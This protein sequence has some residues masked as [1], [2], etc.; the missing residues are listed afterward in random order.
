VTSPLGDAFKAIADGLVADLARSRADSIARAN[1]AEDTRIAASVAEARQAAAGHQMDAQWKV[2]LPRARFAL[3][4]AIDS[5]GLSE[6]TDSA[7]RHDATPALIDLFNANPRATNA[8]ISDVLAPTFSNFLRRRNA[9]FDRAS[10][11]MKATADSLALSTVER[12][13]FAQAASY[14]LVRLLGADLDPTP[15][16]ISYYIQPVVDSIKAVRQAQRKKKPLR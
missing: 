15:L 7:F 14:P 1:A 4:T 8:D 5:L 3:E 9:F 12:P 2:F 6:K 10:A 13:R 11:V 16:M